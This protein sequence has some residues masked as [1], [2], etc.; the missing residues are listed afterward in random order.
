M[1]RACGASG[2]ARGATH[3][4]GPVRRSRRVDRARRAPRSGGRSRGAGRA[5]RARQRRGRALRRRDREFVGDAV[6]A[7]FGIPQAHEDDPERAVSAALAVRDASRP[8]RPESRNGTPPRW[9][10]GSASTRA[11]SLSSRESAARGELMVS[12]DVVN[13]RPASAGCRARRG[14]GRR[15]PRAATSRLVD[16]EIAAGS[17]RGKT[18][19]V[20]R[21]SRAA[22]A[23]IPRGAASKGFR[24]RSSAGTR[25]SPSLR[26]RGPGRAGSRASLVT[27]FGPAGS[28]SPAARRV[29]RPAARRA[30]AQGSLPPVRRRHHL[31]AAR[32]GG[33]ASRGHP[34]DRPGGWRSR[35]CARGRRASSPDEAESVVEAAAWTIGL[36]LPGSS[37][38]RVSRDVRARLYGAWTRYVAALGRERPTVLA[39]E[40]IH[41]ASEP[42][43]DLLDHLA[44]ALEDSSVLIVCPARPSS[45]SRARAGAR[46]SRTRSPSTCPRC[47]PRTLVGSSRRSR[48]RAAS[49]R[50]L[51]SRS[52]RA[53]RAIRSTSR[54]SEDADRAGRDRA[55]DGG[56]IAT[57]RLASP[58]PDSVHG[59]IA[60]RVD[61]LDAPR[62]GR[63]AP[64]L[65]DRADLLAGRG[66][67]RR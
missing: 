8:S 18:T 57:E 43:L 24:R 21:G 30:A 15:P 38:R 9:G 5:V 6:L 26:R 19:P 25:S 53:P 64:L 61:L 4:H 31:L 7:V 35:S 65:G 49:S 46:A 10:C 45:S 1:T 50:T 2:G 67:C 62:A 34:R 42:L 29:R 11:R 60:A 22:F 14:S 33:E 3:R 48:C 12:G 58:I 16:Y 44:D 40:D 27:F 20:R 63:P 51:A 54:R 13:S 23:A 28:A 41:W 37:R 39:I 56:W 32:R 55:R 36:A 66:P 59:V 17:R 52:S 47:P